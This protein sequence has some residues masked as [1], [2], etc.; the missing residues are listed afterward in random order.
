MDFRES[1]WSE[2]V[3][4][5]L[6]GRRV[7]L[8]SPQARA[9]REQLRKRVGIWLV[10]LVLLAFVLSLPWGL[11]GCATAEDITTQVCYLR[12]MG[13]SEEGYTVVMQAC[14]SPESFAASQQ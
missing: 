12:Y 2:R 5:A 13:K 3:L 10:R 9:E 7:P 11:S 14:Q 1:N 8:A 4:D 6:F